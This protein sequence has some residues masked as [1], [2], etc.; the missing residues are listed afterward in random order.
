MLD[1]LLLQNCIG[2]SDLLL[3][4]FL[5]L[6]RLGVTM[7]LLN[8]RFIAFLVLLI[9][10]VIQKLIEGEGFSILNLMNRVRVV[11]DEV[12]ERLGMETESAVNGF[13][14][15]N[16]AAECSK[17]RRGVSACLLRLLQGKL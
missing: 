1:N 13:L 4:G 10:R 15:L 2:S 8:I 9:L 7:P 6:T 17:L 16:E 11:V 12:S 3:S 5:V 14:V